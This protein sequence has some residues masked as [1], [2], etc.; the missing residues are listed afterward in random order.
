MHKGSDWL[1]VIASFTGLCCSPLSRQNLGS[2]TPA[3]G[4][5]NDHVG[6]LEGAVI[7]TPDD[8]QLAKL[9][10][11]FAGFNCWCSLSLASGSGGLGFVR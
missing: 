4:G 5:E 1:V 8:P 9:C 6:F 10:W 3:H 11:S 2:G 7:L